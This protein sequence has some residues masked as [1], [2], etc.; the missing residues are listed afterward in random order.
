MFDFLRKGA[1]SLF[2]KLFLAVI[3]IVF[4][5]WGIGYYGISDRGILAEVNGEKINLK[6]F[7]EY[8]NFK[9]LQLKQ[10]FGEASREDLEKM[11]FKDLVLQDLIRIKLTQKLAQDLGLKVTQEEINFAISQLPAFQQEGR[12]NPS[13]YLTFLREIGLTPAT[14]EK[15]IRADLLEQKLKGLLMATILVSQDEVLEFARFYNQKL[16]LQEYTLSIDACQRDVRWDEKTLE[17]YFNA[18]RDLYVEE[19]KVKISYYALP[20]AGEVEVREE[21][22]KNYYAQNINRFRE[23]FKVKLRRI[24][25]PAHDPEAQKKAQETRG[26]IKDLKDFAV[27]GSKTS[28]WF[29]DQAL[30]EEL[31]NILKI[32]K[33]GDILGPIK[34]SQGYMIL[35]VEEVQ[36]ERVAKLEEVK[37]KILSEIKKVKLREKV[38]NQAN[39]LYTKIITE[40]GLKRWAEKNQVKLVETGYLTKEE[41]SKLFNS[42]EVGNKVFK[43]GK[44]D[45]LSPLETEKAIYLVE[46]LD[47]RPKRNLTFEEAKEKVKGDFLKEKGKEICEG[48]VKGFLVKAKGTGNPPQLAQE[49]GFQVQT[50]EVLRKDSPEILVFRGKPGLIEEP[51]STGEAIKIYYIQKIEDSPQNPSPEE[52]KGFRN[53]LL[54][55]KR[56]EVLKRYLEGYQKRAKIKVYPLFKQI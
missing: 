49:M 39:E 50:R 1:T 9:F 19:E 12:F 24:V 11:K 35:G 23:P 53:T 33:K 3:V 21:E 25:V 40:N 43:Q 22:I 54:E 20:I 5:F 55:M 15:M 30:P 14:F 52:L 10:V 16:T 18:H 6:E 17:S 7:Q 38:K 8:Y 41:L 29:E 47:K 36:P 48:R 51:V 27:F 42:Q 2:A 26:K 46:I 32:A 28:E 4:V 34:T 31:K 56:E 37:E 45:Y 13:G 44:G